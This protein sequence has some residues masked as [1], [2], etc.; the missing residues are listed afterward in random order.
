MAEQELDEPAGTP[1]FVIQWPTASAVAMINM[2]L[3]ALRIPSAITR[4]RLVQWKPR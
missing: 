1:D 2:M 4:Q 3:A